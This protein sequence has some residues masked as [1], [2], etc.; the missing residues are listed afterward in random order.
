[1]ADPAPSPPIPPVLGVPAPP[2][3]LPTTYREYY[4]NEANNTAGGDVWMWPTMDPRRHHG[5]VD[6]R[7]S[8]NHVG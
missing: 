7:D 6:T 3:V 2:G 5:D 8:L 4:D 1:M